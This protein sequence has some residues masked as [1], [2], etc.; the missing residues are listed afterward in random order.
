MS[1]RSCSTSHRSSWR[2]GVRRAAQAGLRHSD[3]R[4]LSPARG[5]GGR[6]QA[7]LHLPPPD[8]KEAIVLMPTRTS[9]GS[10]ATTSCTWRTWS[11]SRTGTA[12]AAL[13]LLAPG[14][15]RARVLR[16]FGAA[17]RGQGR[18]GEAAGG[19]GEKVPEA[20]SAGAE[21]RA[22]VGA[23]CDLF[24]SAQP[25][26]RDRRRRLPAALQT[27]SGWSEGEYVA[28][29]QSL[30]EDLCGKVPDGCRRS[31]MG[32]AGKRGRSFQPWSYPRAERRTTRE[33]ARKWASYSAPTHQRRSEPLPMD[34]ATAFA[35]GQAATLVLKKS[36]HTTKW[37]S[38][39]H[40]SLR[41]HA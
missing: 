15:G 6:P 26:R 8:C 24:R 37:S 41:V 11:R 34:A 18:T 27:T 40:P 22:R 19:H 13:V 1:P 32:S 21:F 38:Q 31:S 30:G 39:R 12:C 14:D 23:I 5:R 17:F 20:D 7:G 28:T 29:I 36:H 10:S 33:R 35:V 25:S 16:G 2:Q 9:A 4:G 3:R